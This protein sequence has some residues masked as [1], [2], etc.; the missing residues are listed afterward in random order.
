VREEAAARA[1]LAAHQAEAAAHV[2]GALP[3]IRRGVAAGG[4]RDI[5]LENFTVSNGGRELISDASVTL[6]FG[7]R[8]G[9]IGRNGTGRVWACAKRGGRWHVGRS[10]WFRC[11]KRSRN[12]AL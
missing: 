8:Y 10:H 3:T 4:A 6:A 9:L 12:R 11:W 1:A 7:R 5:H 2:A